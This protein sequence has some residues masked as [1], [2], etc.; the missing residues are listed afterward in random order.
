M[1]EINKPD[2]F[3][4]FQAL[5]DSLV[6]SGIP[7]N[8]EDIADVKEVD[9]IKDIIGNQDEEEEEIEEEVKPK[10]KPKVEVEEEEES[11]DESEEEEESDVDEIIKKNK[12]K[13]ES[14]SEE[15]DLAEFEPDIAKFFQD[16]LGEELGWEFDEEEKFKS[17]KELV[18]YMKG[19][20]EESSRPIYANEEIEKLNEF[21]TNGGKLEDYYKVLKPGGIDVDTLDI[22]SDADLKLAIREK[23]I[24]QGN[25]E[26]RIKKIISRYED[27][28]ILHEEGEDAVEFLKDYKTQNSQ[29]LL[30]DAR[31]K[32]EQVKLQQQKFYST[33]ESNIKSLENIRGI[34]ISSKDKQDLLD[35]IF[36]PDSEGITKYQRDYM[37]DVRNLI[38]SAYFT[39]QG[40]KLISTAKK[41]G[42]SDAYKDLHQKLKANKGKRH[43]GGAGGQGDSDSSDSLTN[44]LGRHLMKK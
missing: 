8:E 43:S 7:K 6:G 9:D 30:E 34:K 1:A 18:D 2:I 32:A 5:S 14:V 27:N 39:K 31:N 38:E 19:V 13:D 28:D 37:T 10:K 26:D 42:T 17:V 41:T 21:V 11:E 20:V 44:L 22:N 24:L 36:K 15:S 12:T 25:K 16:K 29:R 3:G 40:D 4:G 33:V 35:Y 23:L